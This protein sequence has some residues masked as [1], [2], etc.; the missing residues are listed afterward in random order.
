MSKDNLDHE[1]RKSFGLFTEKQSF[2]YRLAVHIWRERHPWCIYVMHYKDTEPAS[3]AKI[4]ASKGALEHA[5]NHTLVY[6]CTGTPVQYQKL[7]ERFD[8]EALSI[9]FISGPN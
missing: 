1:M 8:E 6:F 7:A 9:L 4:E 2:K 5:A 3:K